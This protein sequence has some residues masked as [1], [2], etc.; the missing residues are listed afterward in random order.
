MQDKFHHLTH[1]IFVGNPDG[2]ELLK[3]FK[4]KLNAVR[5]FPIAPEFIQRHGNALGYAN[6]IEGQ[7]SFID[8]ID[9]VIAEYENEFNKKR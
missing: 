3:I 4:D 9:N 6:F 5:I 8:Y 7:K 2:Q 1:K